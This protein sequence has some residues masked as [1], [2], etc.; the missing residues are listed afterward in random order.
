[1]K[2]REWLLQEMLFNSKGILRYGPGI[3]AIVEVDQGVADFY[4]KLIP[5]YNYVQPQMYPAHITVVRTA[6]ENPKNMN[7]WGKYEGEEIPFSY[8][9]YVYNNRTYWYLNVQSDRIGDIREE[10]GLPRFRF[11]E[12]GADRRGY[13]ITIGNVKNG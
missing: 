1:V 2:F 12:L 9:N 11:G 5:K 10:L 3:R 7:V 4:R 13:H 6:K 8:D